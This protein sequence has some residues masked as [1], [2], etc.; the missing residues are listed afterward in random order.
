[1][2][3]IFGK[4]IKLKQRLKANAGKG[5]TL[6]ELLAAIAILSLIVFPTMQAFVIATKYNSKARTELQATIVANAVL[7]SARVNT[8]EK[9]YQECDGDY[10]GSFDLIAGNLKSG[11]IVN[12]LDDS[13]AYRGYLVSYDA[14]NSKYVSVSTSENYASGDFKNIDKFDLVQDTVTYTKNDLTNEIS[15]TA[16]ACYSYIFKGITQ[17][18][19]KY[20]AIMI[21]EEAPYQNIEVS[22]SG[23][24]SVTYTEQDVDGVFSA[25]TQKFNITVY[26]YKKGYNPVDKKASSLDDNCL[27]KLTGS[28]LDNVKEQ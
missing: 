7:E 15:P 2:K 18:N 1:M 16:T 9:I 21:L 22:D 6:V 8:I 13:D 10:S 28:K 20:D 19:S 25:S 27:V 24:N 23:G 17:S 14:A 4:L 26:V 11:K 5:F 12:F 3:G